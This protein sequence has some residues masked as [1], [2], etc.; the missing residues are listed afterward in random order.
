[1][2]L[3]AINDLERLL[4]TP[5]PPDLGPKPRA[6][7]QSEA[8]LRANLDSLFQQAT[9]PTQQQQLIR[10]LLLLWH[11]HL[12]SAHTIAQAIETPDG[13]FVHALMHRREPD[14]WNAKYWWRRVGASHPAFPGIA[15]CAGELLKARGATELTA[16]LLPDGKWNPHAF[17]D[18][19]EQVAL[20]GFPRQEELLR[21]V[22]R[23]ET[24]ALLDFFC[25]D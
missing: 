16:K 20:G 4:A 25:H 9:L 7:V 17:V 19:C 1:M 10:A 5:E 15:R 14:Y 2:T 6:N 21:E 23:V 24:E 3:Q 22:Q 8:A 12:D 13:S 18:A 11:D